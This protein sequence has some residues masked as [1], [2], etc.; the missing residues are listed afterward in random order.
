M[1]SIVRWL[2]V[3]LLGL[4]GCSS[5]PEAPSFARPHQAEEV[6]KVWALLGGDSE[7]PTPT[8]TWVKGETCSGGNPMWPG[9]VGPEGS[10][11]AGLFDN[12]YSGITLVLMPSW[13]ETAIVHELTHAAS[14]MLRGDADDGHV[15]FPAAWAAVPSINDQIAN[16]PL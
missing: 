8:I 11:A 4:V 10:C 7:I 9:I 2:L 6:A 13:K 12:D 3:T 1:R 16:D 15:L 14:Y 5:A